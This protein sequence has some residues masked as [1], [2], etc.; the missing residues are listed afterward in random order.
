MQITVLQA[1]YFHTSWTVPFVAAQVKARALGLSGPKNKL[2]S[3][4]GLK[5]CQYSDVCKTILQ[6][7][8]FVRAVKGLDAEAIDAIMAK[9]G[10]SV[11]GMVAVDSEQNGEEMVTLKRIHEAIAYQCCRKERKRNMHQ[12]FKLTVDDDSNALQY[13][14]AQME[15]SPQ[16]AC[17]CLESLLAYNIGLSATTRDGASLLHLAAKTGV[18]EAVNLI[19]SLPKIQVDAKDAAGMTA[20]HYACLLSRS[21]TRAVE[22]LELMVDSGATID[23]RD[24]IGRTPLMLACAVGNWATAYYLWSAGADINAF[25]NQLRTPMHYLVGCDT[26]YFQDGLLFRQ[27]NPAV[28]AGEIY[29]R[30]QIITDLVGYKTLLL[31]DAEGHSP[32]EVARDHNHG[33]LYDVLHRRFECM[34]EFGKPIELR[35]FVADDA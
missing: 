12:L 13:C 33:A 3:P 29:Q 21:Q 30:C 14:L 27:T 24:A 6:K 2:L 25:D 7:R 19:L 11:G 31:D 23:A 4:K 1:M 32:E 16:V 5:S 22:I 8:S 20:L 18:V 26:A 28:Y 15:K 35:E 17:C 10:N 34:G 9:V